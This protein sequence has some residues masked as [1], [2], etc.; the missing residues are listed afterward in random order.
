[1]V[2][3]PRARASAPCAPDKRRPPDAPARRPSAWRPCGT[4]RHRPICRTRRPSPSAPAGRRYNCRPGSGAR[5]PPN[6]S[7]TARISAASSG[8]T[9]SSASISRIQSPRQASIPAWRRG[10]SRSHAPSTMRSVN[11]RAISRER[12]VQRSSTTTSLVGKAEAR[13]AIGE[14]RL[15][16]MRDDQRRERASHRR[17]STRSRRAHA[18]SLR[19]AATAAAPPPRPPRPTATVHQRVGGAV[20]EAR[21]RTSSRPATVG[22]HHRGAAAPRRVLLDR[23]R[24]EQAQGR[25]ARPPRRCASA[26]YRCR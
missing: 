6:C 11:R 20:V 17:R 3:E 8:P 5:P 22:A 4:A 16:V 25:R 10:P 14:L 15:L 19:R 18:A 23:A 9:R 13:Q 24:T 12:S 26:R 2:D 7:T 1:M 21:R